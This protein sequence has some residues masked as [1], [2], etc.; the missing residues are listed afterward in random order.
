MWRLWGVFFPILT[1]TSVLLAGL[2]FSILAQPYLYDLQRKLTSKQN[3]LI[4][5]T[6]TI[7]GFATSA[8]TMLFNYS[9]YGMYLILYFAWGMFLAR[10]KSL[11]KSLNGHFLEEL[12]HL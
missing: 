3:L 1:S 8:G 4:L 12:Y 2:V 11:L 9:I 7:V 10:E 6:L 5:C